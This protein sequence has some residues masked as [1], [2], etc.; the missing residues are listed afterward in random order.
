MK[1]T[2]IFFAGVASG[3]ILRSSFDSFRDVAVRGVSAWF[4]ASER[5]RRFVAVEREYFEDLMAEARARYGARLAER[6][7]AQASEAAAVTA[8]S[9]QA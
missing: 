1:N 4:D 5:A 7:S 3:W 8:P 9:V 6:S 2:A